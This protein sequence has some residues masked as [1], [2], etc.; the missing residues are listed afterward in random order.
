MPMISA[1]LLCWPFGVEGLDPV[2]LH[3]WV[4]VLFPVESSTI[5]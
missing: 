5:P 2:I 1:K 4:A 3:P